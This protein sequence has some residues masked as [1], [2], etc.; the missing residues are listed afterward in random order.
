MKITIYYSSSDRR[1]PGSVEIYRPSLTCDEES[2]RFTRNPFEEGAF[3][4]IHSFDSL[5]DGTS[6]Y[7][8][9][10]LSQHCDSFDAY[11]D[12]LAEN[13]DRIDIND[14]PWWISP[15]VDAE[16]EAGFVL[17]EMTAIEEANDPTC[18]I[19]YHVVNL[20][21]VAALTKDSE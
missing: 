15:R 4:L 3:C 8:K 1:L 14:K 5:E 18:S 9:P 12:W 10:L 17:C 7:E 6:A 13:V 2:L 19:S 21:P 20:P 16:G 11:A